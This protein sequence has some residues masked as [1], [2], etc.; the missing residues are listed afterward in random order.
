MAKDV[1]LRMPLK[2]LL[3]SPFLSQAEVAREIDRRKDRQ[4][5]ARMNPTLSH[6]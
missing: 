3:S 4:L 5:W 6:S 2:E 1:L